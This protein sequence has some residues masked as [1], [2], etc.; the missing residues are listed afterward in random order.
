[1]IL[2]HRAELLQIHPNREILA[3]TS[4]KVQT[5][6]ILV[7]YKYIHLPQSNLKYVSSGTIF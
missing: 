4:S 1:M 7:I 3:S 2:Y 6:F 5:L